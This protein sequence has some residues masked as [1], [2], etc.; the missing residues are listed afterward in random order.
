MIKTP[1]HKNSLVVNEKF[2]DKFNNTKQINKE[3]EEICKKAGKLFK[4][5]LEET[6]AKNIT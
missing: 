4:R 5:K 1:L 2:I 3:H 6:N